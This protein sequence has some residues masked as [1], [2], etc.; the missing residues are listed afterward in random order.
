[1]DTETEKQILAELR[2][3]NRINV[4]G[5]V[6]LGVLVV[7]FVVILAFRD[8]ITS[9]C[10]TGVPPS[11]SWR[12]AN[13]LVDKGDFQKGTEMIRRLIAKHPDYYYGYK[14]MGCVEHE[15]G[16]LE[17]TE[18]NY[19]KA[20]DLF[21]TEDNEKDLAAIRK[22]IEKKNKAANKASEAITPQGGAQPQR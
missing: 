11:D 22:A 10:R 12:E 8:R 18:V 16:N 9:S 17:E 5:L 3:Q 13:A 4:I 20:Y 19:A 7:L 6:W 2:K 15:L 1:M 21:P 14:L